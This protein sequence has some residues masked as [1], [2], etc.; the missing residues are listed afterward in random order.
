MLQ[1]MIFCLNSEIRIINCRKWFIW[2]IGMRF[3]TALL[4]L[5][6]KSCNIK[7]EECNLQE[8]D[9]LIKFPTFSPTFDFYITVVYAFI[10][11]Y[12][13][14]FC[15]ISLTYKFW[16]LYVWWF[17]LINLQ[18]V[19]WIRYFGPAFSIQVPHKSLSLS[20][21]CEAFLSFRLIG[22][23]DQ[24]KVEMLLFIYLFIQLYLEPWINTLTVMVI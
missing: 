22:F 17:F 8:I 18:S 21:A 11:S 15:T 20:H 9:S 7:S 13:L 19:R 6:K 14:W 3:Y 5:L 2:K 1:F 10:C 16:W 12:W 24:I 4:V 23:S